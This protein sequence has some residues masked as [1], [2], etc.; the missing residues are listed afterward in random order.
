[1]LP[2]QLLSPQ[3]R[4]RPVPDA[5][6]GTDQTWRERLSFDGDAGLLFD[7]C[8]G[9]A[10]CAAM[11][12]DAV[13]HV[14]EV[15]AGLDLDSRAAS[16]AAGLA[17]WQQMDP[18]R[19]YSVSAIEQGVRDTRGFFAVRPR[20]AASWLDPQPA[21]D[22][23]S[24][25]ASSP[26]NQ[27]SASPSSGPGQPSSGRGLRATLQ[28]GLMGDLEAAAGILRPLGIERILK[29]GGARINGIDAPATGTMSISASAFTGGT[30]R[31][32]RRVA[33]PSRKRAVEAGRGG[34]LRLRVTAAGRRLLAR[35]RAL[36]LTLRGSFTDRSGRVTRAPTRKVTIRRKSRR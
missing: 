1:V 35:G 8:L 32:S 31:A 34:V 26:A 25:D 11:Y 13:R 2:Q 29:R 19:E 5:P 23:S 4:F 18:R 6:L 9:D 7:K 28:A 21:S 36:A 27:S 14:A 15:I 17:S 16:I 12:R 10:T 33:G 22:A 30:A 20:D 24:A 3:R